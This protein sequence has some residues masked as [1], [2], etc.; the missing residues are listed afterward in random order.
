MSE[1]KT[2]TGNDTD[3]ADELFDRDYL[4]DSD[5]EFLA[6]LDRVLSSET[7][8]KTA[9][10]E[11]PSYDNPEDVF[12]EDQPH[13]SLDTESLEEVADD[14]FDLYS[15]EEITTAD[16]SAAELSSLEDT[17][18]DLAE[19]VDE[20]PELEEV[21]ELAPDAEPEPDPELEE[22]PEELDLDALGGQSE[23]D[24]A[25]EDLSL[26]EEPTQAADLDPGFDS[27][28]LADEQF[29]ADALQDP[30]TAQADLPDTGESPA[31]PQ[32]DAAESPAEPVDFEPPA[33]PET[34][35]EPKSSGGGLW[36]GIAAVLGLV[37][38]GAGGAGLW[39]ANEAEER[40][41]RL[42]Q[43]PKVQMAASAKPATAGKADG[44]DQQRLDSLESS[45]EQ[46]QRRLDQLAE[47]L[48][49]GLAAQEQRVDSSMGE[50]Q[51]SLEGLQGQVKAFSSDIVGLDQRLQQDAKALVADAKAS[52]T[53]EPIVVE[54]PA[55]LKPEVAEKTPAKKT[56]AAVEE[57]LFVQKPEPK[58]IEE[59][60]PV[61]S[62]PEPQ[63][64]AQN[65]QL[66]PNR[67]GGNWSVNLQSF[68][69]E[70]AAIKES[71]RMKAR[72]IPAEISQASSKG[73]TWYRVKVTGFASFKEAKAYTDQIRGDAELSSAWVGRN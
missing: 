66:Q 51:A 61:K 67:S 29:A 72:G 69:K 48:K 19:T 24:W 45:A 65:P 63:A 36:A 33:Q 46:L 68:L 37:G 27:V 56:E 44:M 57:K 11:A 64:V 4:S 47:K 25:D 2:P 6:E 5:S 15:A 16:G 3:N 42:E 54:Q 12:K 53:A 73:K 26:P 39:V 55:Q 14:V 70:Q 9:L 34:A 13:K 32:G 28:E 23:P 52:K 59:K 10:P 30:E 62:E 8:D 43:T 22:F 71:R 49:Q 17:L 50:I 18:Q 58:P 21:V 60:P 35:A 31:S 20:K 40:I 41:A 7:E 38:L 1:K